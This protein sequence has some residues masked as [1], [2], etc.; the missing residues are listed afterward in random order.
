M[1]GKIISH[2]QILEEIGAGGMGDFDVKWQM[3]N[4]K[5]KIE[6]QS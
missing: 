4:I 6:K 5:C 1:I 3:L 2:Y